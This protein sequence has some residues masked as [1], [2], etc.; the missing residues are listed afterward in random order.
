M[1][2]TTGGRRLPLT[3]LAVVVAAGTAF[4]GVAPAQA[5]TTTAPAADAV[6][7]AA[8]TTAAVRIPAPVVRPEWFDFGTQPVF[9]GLFEVDLTG[10][11]EG[12]D[13]HY[14]YQL[15]G[16][17]PWRTGGSGSVTGYTDEVYLPGT[18]GTHLLSVRVA[19]T[20]DGAAVVG[21]AS[22]PQEA[23]FVGG[24]LE[25]TPEVI[26]DGPSVTFRWDV[27]SAL[28]GFTPEES[29]IYYS[30]DGAPLIEVGGVGSLTV[31]PGYGKRVSFDLTFGYIAD[32]YREVHVDGLTADAPGAKALTAP[33]P[34]I[35]GTAEYGQTLSVRTGTWQPAPVELEY[36][37][38]RDGERIRGAEDPTY[39][40]TAYDAGHRITVSVRGSRDGYISQT[41]TSGP[42]KR[43]AAPVITAG[44]PR[45]TGNPVVGR[46]LTAQPGVW[47]PSSLELG[48]QWK[49][50]GKAI[51]G[52][53]AKTYTLTEA[54]RGHTVTAVVSAVIYLYD[55][56]ARASAGVKVR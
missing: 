38:F 28:N 30:V 51:A 16:T 7:A 48:Y 40:V 35:V 52:A 8:S 9:H 4:A 24:S 47:K 15:D 29:A 56:Q 1:I 13:L 2:R 46:T 19:G 6:P 44:T 50:H 14:E 33:L 20:V 10:I 53:T 37:W 41:R 43:I 54:D 23:R 45:I 32:S 34:S 31:T 26:V 12:A 27:R 5:A 17:G 42:T 49:R 39:T 22:A 3:A 55:N 18:A 36:R 11:P 21:A 25:Y